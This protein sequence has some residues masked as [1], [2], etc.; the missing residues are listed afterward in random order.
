MSQ[1]HE[2]D[3]HRFIQETDEL[4]QPFSA[5]SDEHNHVFLNAS[6]AFTS[7][8]AESFDTD[9]FQLTIGSGA[10]STATPCKD[11][12]IKGTCK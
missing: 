12:F 10:S 8:P 7:A 5:R 11:D 2:N 3:A 9:S 1:C 4:H 6:D